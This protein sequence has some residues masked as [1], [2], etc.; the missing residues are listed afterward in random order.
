MSFFVGSRGSG[1]G[2]SIEGFD[3]DDGSAGGARSIDMSISLSRSWSMGDAVV[4]VVG[5]GAWEV[6]GSV[7][8]ALPSAIIDMRTDMWV[9]SSASLRRL[10]SR[11]HSVA[12]WANL[13]MSRISSISEFIRG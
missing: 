12:G 6:V 4:V 10:G 8:L 7:E 2:P 1:R 11:S 9:G 5:C 13:Y 3:D